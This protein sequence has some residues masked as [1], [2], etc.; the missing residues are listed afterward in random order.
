MTLDVD[1][2]EG[3]AAWFLPDEGAAATD[4]WLDQLNASFGVAPPVFRHVMRDIPTL[5]EGC[6][7]IGSRTASILLIGCEGLASN[8]SGP[9]TGLPPATRDRALAP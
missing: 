5:A 2:A 4:R 7:R 3:A 1:G 9:G 6:E 8:D